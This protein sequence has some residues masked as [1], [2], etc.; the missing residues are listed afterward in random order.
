VPPVRLARACRSLLRS[1]LLGVALLAAGAARAAQD[2]PRLPELLDRL[3]AAKDLAAARELESEIWELWTATD[4]ATAAALMAEGQRQLAARAWPSALA[5]FARLV[6][7]KPDFAE[8]WNKR[9]TVYYLMGDYRASVLDI[10][11]TLALE[12]RH[13]GALSGLGLIFMTTEQPQAALRAFEAALAIHPYLPGGRTH[14]EA[15]RQQLQGE[16]L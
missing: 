3:A 12:P 9:A 15:L 13:F 4:D 10:Q 11:R 7:L 16:P 6:A 1:C 5:T 2:D 8:A 14:V